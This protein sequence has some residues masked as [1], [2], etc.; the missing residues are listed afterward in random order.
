MRHIELPP[1]FKELIHEAYCNTFIIIRDAMSRF[2]VPQ[3]I[4]IVYIPEQIL[5]RSCHMTQCM[6][7]R[8]SAVQKL[9]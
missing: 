3:N 5:F 7:V 6:R 9:F 2:R 8:D 4:Q 1:C